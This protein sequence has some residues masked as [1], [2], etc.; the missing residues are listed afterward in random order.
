MRSALSFPFTLPNGSGA[1]QEKHFYIRAT[2]HYFNT[3]IP[4]PKPKANGLATAVATMVN[5]PTYLFR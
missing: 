5:Q 4:K 3:V 2:L 1:V